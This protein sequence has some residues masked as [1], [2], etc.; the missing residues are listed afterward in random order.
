[1]AR[2]V[3]SV[4]YETIKNRENTAWRLGWIS[5]AKRD[6]VVDVDVSVFGSD[7]CVELCC[8]EPVL[9]GK[10]SEKDLK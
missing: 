4:V 6:G 5:A 7:W 8:H 3:C 1:M 2:W 10:E 9:V